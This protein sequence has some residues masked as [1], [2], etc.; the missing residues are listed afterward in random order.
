MGEGDTLQRKWNELLVALQLEA[1][2]S[3]Q[4]LL[5]SYLNRVYLGV[6]WG[7]EDASRAY[8][9]Q[10]ASTLSLPQAA[11]LVGLLPSPNGH[12]PA[13][14]QRQRWRHAMVCSTRWCTRGASQPI[15]DASPGEPDSTGS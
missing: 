6:G 4:A 9:N 7:F 8:F 1:R 3:K 15:K 11:L 12:D 14:I 10:S 5:L 2:F 13:A